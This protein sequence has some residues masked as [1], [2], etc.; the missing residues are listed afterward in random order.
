MSALRVSSEP[1]NLR[2]KL[3]PGEMI[4]SPWWKSVEFWPSIFSQLSNKCGVSDQGG[5]RVHV[6]RCIMNTVLDANVCP[7]ISRGNIFPFPFISC[8]WLELAWYSSIQLINEVSLDNWYLIVSVILAF[9]WW[10]AVFIAI[11]KFQ[12]ICQ[13]HWSNVSLY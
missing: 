1:S 6:D 12:M 8:I 9:E 7:Y 11:V 5:D 3:V 4:F 2:K 10:T 13:T